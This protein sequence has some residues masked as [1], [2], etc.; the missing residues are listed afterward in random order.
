[1]AVHL[2]TETGD[3]FEKA[4]QFL[5]HLPVIGVDTETTGLDPFSN[6]VLLIQLGNQYEQY[7]FDVARLGANAINY[8]RPILEN[9]NTIKVLHNAKFDYRFLK[10][11]HSIEM[12]NIYDTM[13]AEQLLQK[14]RK[15]SGFSLLDVSEKYAGQKMDKSHQS[16]FS[17][18][19]FGEKFTTG[20]I[21][22]AGMDVAY[23]EKIMR[24]QNML[25]RRDQLER[26]RDIEMS[27]IQATADMELNG[28]RIDR[29]KWLI[30]EAIARVEKQKALDKLDVMVAPYVNCDMFGKP[31][32]NYNSPKQL[33]AVLQK[34]V[35]PNIKTTKEDELKEINHPMVFALL[36]YRGME[37]RITTYGA[38]FIEDIPTGYW[39][40]K[41]GRIHSDF[42]QVDTDTGRYS[43]SDPNLQNIPSKDDDA[44]LYREAFVAH[45]D[46]SLLI[47]ADYSN[48][49]L[50]LL[51]DLS[52]EPSWIDIFDT[53]KDMHCAIGSMLFGVP[54]RQKGTLGP[55]DP[56]EN[57]H[58][59]KKVKSI[60][61]GVGY[62][63]GSQKLSRELRT[64]IKEAKDLLEKY[65][66]KFPKVKT[67]FEQHVANSIANRCVR[68][69]YDNRLRWLEGF[70]FDSK[71]DLARI[72]NMTMNF[73]MQSGNASIT[74]IAMTSVR[75]EIKKRELPIKLICTIHDEIILNA[76][77]D[78]AEEG[79]AMLQKC[80]NDAAGLYVKNVK[81]KVESSIAP[82]WK[83]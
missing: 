11:V 49:E 38:T 24:E 57:A 23:L 61:F 16:T 30:P 35:S 68:S 80:M 67:F 50:R 48:M 19:V 76:R 21:E 53:G 75:N 46:D 29:E 9:Q 54:I 55:D 71:R 25:I 1:M 73:P 51:A 8:L 12:E 4:L 34:A 62:G 58:L 26:V 5:R 45:D 18:M 42:K 10:A 74:K 36:D 33:L 47:D 7:V 31:S 20:Q 60:N 43:S 59:R 81:I 3:E 52:G 27:V 64:D 63:M 77:K 82:Y 78:Y 39:N 69:P 13:I 6:R 15:M 17:E 22:Y 65:W 44:H 2:L 32:I 28:M 41:T 40:P 79:E 37:K 72:K 70:D 83:K 66:S 56:G 14:G